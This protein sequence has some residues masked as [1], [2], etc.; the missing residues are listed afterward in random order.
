MAVGRNYLGSYRLV[1]LIRVGHT[2][3]IWES[4]DERVERRCALK[5][6]QKEHVHDRQELGYLKNEYEVGRQLDHKYI[7]DTYEFVTAHDLPFLVLEFFSGRNLKQL[8]RQESELLDELT[9]MVIK[10]SA[11]ALSYMHQQGWIHRDIKPDNF[12]VNDEGDVRLIDF[13]IAMKPPRGLGKLFAGKT[14]KIQGTRSYMAPEQIRGAALDPRADIYSFGC[15]LYE[16]LTCKPPFTAVSSNDLLNKHLFA[17]IPVASAANR[18]VTPEFN[19]LVFRMMSKKPE[20]RP[21]SLSMFLRE[22][23]TMRPL[24]S[25]QKPSS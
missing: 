12:M 6:L 23:A 7:I 18:N 14:K 20:Q 8:I 3:Q 10:H 15:V 5:A 11:E 22:Y 16:L 19:N 17:P 13:A 4:I 9:H 25:T 2:C 21:E 1:R 24:K